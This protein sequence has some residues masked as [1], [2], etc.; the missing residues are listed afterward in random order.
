M[1]R[2]SRSGEAVCNQ[3]AAC[4][5]W[6][7]VTLSTAAGRSLLAALIFQEFVV[8]VA[9]TDLKNASPGKIRGSHNK[10]HHQQIERP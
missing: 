8:S 10:N 9:L 7:P 4:I 3:R 5:R 2:A 1:T 6:G